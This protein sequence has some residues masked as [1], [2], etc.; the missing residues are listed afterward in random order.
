MATHAIPREAWTTFFDSFSVD[1]QGADATLE[2]H[3]PELGDQVVARNQI[4]RG[5]SA[6]QKDGENRISIMIGPANDDGMTHS[7]IAPEQVWHKHAEG[8]AGESLE[9]KSAG[10]NSAL[11]RF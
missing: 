9:I 3:G 4:F 5:I 10:D 7:V 11:L 2:A 6:D 8:T 1:H